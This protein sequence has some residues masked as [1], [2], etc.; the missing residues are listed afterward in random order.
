MFFP[1]AGRYNCGYFSGI[2]EVM[3]CSEKL[4]EEE[5]EE[6]EGSL[7]KAANNNEQPIDL[8]LKGS[9]HS[10]WKEMA[11]FA[12]EF[13]SRRV[14]LG[15]T[16][17]DVGAAM[18]KLC[19]S[20]FSQTTISRFEALNL[21]LKNMSKLRP[22]IDNWMQNGQ[23]S[24]RRSSEVMSGQLKRRRKRTCI[25]STARDLLEQSFNSNQKPLSQEMASLANSLNLDKEVVRVWFCN[26]RQKQK[27]KA[28][29]STTKVL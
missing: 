4:E 6:E 29:S 25:D 2:E 7:T 18:G 9:N 11:D 19:G 20:D 13:K 22:L 10:Q 14:K 15:L 12:K 5:E 1:P 28:S 8:S 16:Q 23:E 24:H 27:K 17:G 3:D 21:S 26:R